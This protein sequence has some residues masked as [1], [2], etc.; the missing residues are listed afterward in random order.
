MAASRAFSS[1]LKTVLAVHLSASATS[2][3]YGSLRSGTPFANK[4]EDSIDFPHSSDVEKI[5]AQMYCGKGVPVSMF[6]PDAVFEDP[7]AKCSGV[8]EIVEAFRAL[9]ACRPESLSK[10]RVIFNSYILGSDG[11]GSIILVELHQRYFGALQV[12]SYAVVET[13][14]D[15]L[16]KRV[17]ERW[18]GVPILEFEPFPTVRR[19]NGLFSYALTSTF[20]RDKKDA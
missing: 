1:L 15:G 19:L 12:R 9:K 13:G 11:L 10:P 8:H 16:I 7:A 4:D 5:I 3:A 6:A 18:N 20:I 2:I 14:M 17:E